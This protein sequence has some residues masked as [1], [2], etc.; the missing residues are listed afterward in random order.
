MSINKAP[1][2]DNCDMTPYEFLT[3]MFERTD[4]SGLLYVP[5]LYLEAGNMEEYSYRCEMNWSY[6]DFQKVKDPFKKL[7]KCILSVGDG[8]RGS[9][10]DY[11][12]MREKFTDPEMIS[13][14]DTYLA[15]FYSDDIDPELIGNISEQLDTRDYIG[16]LLK[17]YAAGKDLSDSDIDYVKSYIDDVPTA[18]DML[19]YKRYCRLVREDAKKRVGDAPFSYELILLAMRLCRLI[20]LDAPDVV[21]ENDARM[22]AQTLA[23]HTHCIR[24]EIVDNRARYLAEKRFELSDDEL[25]AFYRPHKTNSRKSMAPLFVYLILKEHSSPTMP[26]SQ[27]DILKLLESYPYEIYIERKALSRIIHNLHDSQIGICSDPHVGTWY[28]PDSEG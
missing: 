26:M 5:R 12:T 13:M 24:Y 19:V 14:I 9:D 27:K 6:Q 22:L 28:E 23:L 17:D 25:D 2:F 20:Y 21:I 7:Y 4:E 3:L 11:E 10:L 8:C 15:P 1:S 16:S 18:E